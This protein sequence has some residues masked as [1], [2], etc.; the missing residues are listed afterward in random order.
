MNDTSRAAQAR[1]YELLRE[2]SPMDRLK[3]AV[4]LTR[5]VRR[6]AEAD[7]LRAD[8]EATPEQVQARL[9]NRLYGEAVAQRLFPSRV[10]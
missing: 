5:S 4:L 8:P 3:T 10:G 9:A 6:L 1:Y 2:Q 7:I